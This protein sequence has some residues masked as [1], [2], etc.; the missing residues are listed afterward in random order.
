MSET[1]E[2]HKDITPIQYI[3]ANY[4]VRDKK[5]DIMDLKL[6]T[7]QKDFFR[8]GQMYGEQRN[9][10]VNKSRKLGYT[11]L[12][13][14]ET[15]MLA[16]MYPGS[17]YPLIA[18]TEPQAKRAL[19]MMKYLHKDSLQKTT[20]IIN[21]SV[22]SIEYD[23][24]SEIQV[25]AGANP[26]GVRGPLAMKVTLDEFAFNKQAG[27]MLDAASP[28]LAQGGTLSVISTPFG[29]NSLYWKLWKEEDPGF[30][31]LIR[32]VFKDMSKFNVHVPLYE[33]DLELV[34]PWLSMDTLEK[35]RSRSITRSGGAAFL[36]E[37]CCLPSESSYALFGAKHIEQAIVDGVWQH[38]AAPPTIG[39]EGETFFVGCDFAL[40]TE[41]SADNSVFVIGKLM[42]DKDDKEEWIEIVNL[43]IEKG[44]HTKEQLDSLETINNA[45]RPVSFYV[46]ENSLG[47][48]IFQMLQ[49][50]IPIIHP[51][52]TS[53]TSKPSIV[54]QVQEALP[55]N[56]LKIRG[57]TTH[58]ERDY[59][60]QWKAEMMSFSRIE[61]KL[62]TNYELKG[63]GEHDDCVMATCIMFQAYIDWRALY[64]PSI[65]M[66]GPKYSPSQRKTDIENEAVDEGDIKTAYAI[67]RRGAGR[68]EKS[69]FKEAIARRRGY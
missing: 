15:D 55:N 61:N 30:V 64:S 54:R 10:I 67:G 11:M 63:A 43:T 49:K 12:D 7:F 31:K 32:P 9:R 56:S 8:A 53:S 68:S 20:S 27:D 19:K 1:L 65:V 5:G 62:G 46:E 16:G 48:P 34:A 38:T 66:S 22:W 33:Q 4:R 13:L 57:G 60:R 29:L 37:Y 47:K 28:M 35:E 18:T 41:A 69:T 52:I 44:M 25:F 14:I 59:L 26:A 6:E 40:S 39:V 42:R 21:D 23:N 45:Y 58:K 51:F 50:R 2:I 36:Q 24:G 3:N 17:F